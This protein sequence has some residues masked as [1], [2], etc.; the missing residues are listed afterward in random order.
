[1]NLAPI[2][3][4][5]Y[6][7]PDHLKQ[8]IESLKNNILA[9]ES[10]VFISSDGFRDENDEKEVIKVRKYINSINSFRDVIIIE[11]II[12]KGLA[13]SIKEG[14]DF[15]LEKFDNI[16]VLEDDLITSVNFLKFMNS[17][18]DLFKN[19]TSVCQINGYSYFEK[20]VTNFK[21]PNNIFLKGSDCLGWAT[22]K[23]SWCNYHNDSEYLY[24]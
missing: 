21:L 16:I 23:R 20:F 19:N 22:W 5:V 17:G 12:N 6:N 7:R 3:L 2:A 18:L 13:R 8:T 11:S 10:V 1:M 4:F 9:K 24:N 15:V 14:I